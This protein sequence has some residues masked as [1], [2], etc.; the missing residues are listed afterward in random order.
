MRFRRRSGE[1]WADDPVAD[2]VGAGEET[3]D[4]GAGTTADVVR[5][6][7]GGPARGSSRSAPIRVYTHG[8]S[9]VTLR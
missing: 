1:S 2:E 6:H 5:P 4:D 7:S 9:R 3:P 8:R